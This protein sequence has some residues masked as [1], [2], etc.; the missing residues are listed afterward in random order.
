MLCCH[1]LVCTSIDA[2]VSCSTSDPFD[3]A[4]VTPDGHATLS[5][6]YLLGSLCTGERSVHLACT[7]LFLD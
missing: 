4:C 6:P 3:T 7:A 2:E 5:L 1:V